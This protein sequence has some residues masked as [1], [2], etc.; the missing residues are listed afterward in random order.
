MDQRV[1]RANTVDG[2]RPA[3]PVP[4][5]ARSADPPS[6][7]AATPQS[8][9]PPREQIQGLAVSASSVTIGHRERDFLQAEVSRLQECSNG[10]G[11]YTQQDWATI[12]TA[13]QSQSRIDARDRERTREAAELIH[14]HRGPPSV[15]AEVAATREARTSRRSRR[16]VVTNC[17]PTGCWDTNGV[18]YNRAAGTGNFLREDGKAC[19]TVAN[20]VICD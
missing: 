18:R 1:L 20:Q 16:S 2:T 5:R 6:E 10:Q 9:C 17:D 7:P 3:P 11:T 8:Y 4:R 12:I 15:Q 14:L 19:R 13:H